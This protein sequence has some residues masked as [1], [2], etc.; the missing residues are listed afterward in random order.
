MEITNHLLLR[1]YI[2]SK[3]S[4]LVLSSRTGNLDLPVLEDNSNKQLLAV[5]QQEECPEQQRYFMFYTGPVRGIV[6]EA[7]KRIKLPDLEIQKGLKF[8]RAITG[9]LTLEIPGP[10]DS[11]IKNADMLAERLSVL[12]ATRDDVKIFRP[13]KMAEGKRS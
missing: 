3:G 1:H 9:A 7:K 2:P 11:V 13:C 8:K 5:Q 12:F 10:D 4:L 6:A